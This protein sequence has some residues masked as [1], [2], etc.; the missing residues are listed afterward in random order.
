MYVDKWA[1]FPKRIP[2][3]IPKTFFGNVKYYLLYEFEQEMHM[4]AYI[5]WAASVKEDNVGVLSFLDYGAHEFIDAHAIDHCVEFFKI[6]R[7]YYIVDKEF[8]DN[9]MNYE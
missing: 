7:I 8:T 5:Q 4:L 2:E 1:N 3:F 6:N 9:V